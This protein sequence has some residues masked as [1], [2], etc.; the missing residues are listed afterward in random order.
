MEDATLAPVNAG[1]SRS[2]VDQLDHRVAVGA[3]SGTV[4][5]AIVA[6]DAGGNV[7][8]LMFGA[9][10]LGIAGLAAAAL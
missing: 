6:L 8:V 10:L 9:L 4:L 5:A 2:L 7:L 1:R 3:V